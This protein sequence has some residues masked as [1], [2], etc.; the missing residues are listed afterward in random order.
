MQKKIIAVPLFIKLRSHER[1]L[2]NCGYGSWKCYLAK[3]R[4]GNLK[5]CGISNIGTSLCDRPSDSRETE[6]LTIKCLVSRVK[7]T[8][9]SVWLNLF[10]KETASSA[11]N[12]ESQLLL[13]SVLEGHSFLCMALCLPFPGCSFLGLTS[14]A[15]DQWS[16]MGYVVLSHKGLLF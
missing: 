1:H 7:L 3:K 12:S 5:I 11:F 6:E 13:E 2:C 8:S 14:S 4:T 10:S 16:Q 9:K 15:S